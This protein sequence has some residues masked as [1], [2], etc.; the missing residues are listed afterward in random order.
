[1]T[2]PISKYCLRKMF[3]KQY[4]LQRCISQYHPKMLICEHGTCLQNAHSLDAYCVGSNSQNL[5]TQQPLKNHM[6]SRILNL[7]L[8]FH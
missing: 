7:K 4:L 6:I 5:V 1:M 8:T 2:P 3:G